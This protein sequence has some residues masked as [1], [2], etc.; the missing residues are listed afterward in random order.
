[1]YDTRVTTVSS[2]FNHSGNGK[3]TRFWWRSIGHC[4]TR[5]LLGILWN[6]LPHKLCK[7]HHLFKTVNQSFADFVKL[8]K[9]LILKALKQTQHSNK[10]VSQERKWGR[11][12]RIRHD[13]YQSCDAIK[14]NLVMAVQPY[15]NNH[16]T[17]SLIIYNFGKQCYLSEFV[18]VTGFDPNEI[19]HFILSKFSKNTRS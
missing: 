19:R 7:R 8:D 16:L 12:V 2:K 18:Y 11:E 4:K 9:L 15:N 14:K 5:P 3:S 10:M 13:I 17:S 1:M 6:R